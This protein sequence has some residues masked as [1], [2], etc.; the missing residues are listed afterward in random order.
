VGW[1]MTPDPNPENLETVSGTLDEMAQPCCGKWVISLKED[2]FRYE[3]K[4]D[5]M[6]AFLMDDMQQKVKRGDS[7]TF[8]IFKLKPSPF[9]PG[10][11]NKPV[12]AV[13]GGDQVFLS[14]EDTQEI[15]MKK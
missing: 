15:R 10:G 8:Q 4:K 9:N 14:L 13:K 5:L 12:A 6:K 2:D 3:I 7:V 11:K 1:S